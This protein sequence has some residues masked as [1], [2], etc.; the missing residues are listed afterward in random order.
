MIG[1]E[2]EE[3]DQ[4]L[5]TY[6]IKMLNKNVTLSCNISRYRITE[7]KTGSVDLSEECLKA[8]HYLL[9]KETKITV[10]RLR[11]VQDTQQVN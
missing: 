7:N 10:A 6:S 5:H 2:E 4:K 1:E 9:Q 11:K 3:D 8:L